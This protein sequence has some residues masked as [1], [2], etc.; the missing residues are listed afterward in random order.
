MWKTVNSILSRDRVVEQGT[1]FLIDEQET[2]D[3][4]QIASGFNQYFANVGKN[5]AT[6]FSEAPQG[7]NF[8]HYLGARSDVHFEFKPVNEHTVL[9]ILSSIKNTAPGIDDIPIMD[10]KN[11]FIR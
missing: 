10:L 9:D 11:I 8:L 4:L 6:A 3:E 7:N 5:F 2:N 1:S